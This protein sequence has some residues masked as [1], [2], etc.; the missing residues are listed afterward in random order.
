MQTNKSP[1]EQKLWNN[2]HDNKDNDAANELIEN[3]MY[4][5]RFHVDRMSSHL[6]SNVSRDDLNSFGLI[7]LFDALKKFDPTR[8]LKFDTYASFRVR[9]AIIDGLRKEDWLPRS[10]REKT[11]KIEKVS[12][13]LE[14]DYQRAPSSEEIAVKAGLNAG[15]VE[16]LIQ[17]TLVANVLSIE[18]K[19]KGT[20]IDR[21]EGVGYAIPDKAAILPDEQMM[22]LEMNQEL[23]EGIKSLNENEQM[24]IDLFYHKELTLTEIGQV[25]GLTTSRISQ[26][27]RKA[28]FK[29]RHTLQKIQA[30]ST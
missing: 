23:A 15:E 24:V 17:D 22:K 10:T 29:L 8:D 19:R 21:H 13:E 11:K 2:W 3:Y 1:L 28:I 25:L 20:A 4:L 16:T 9:G 18:E 26:I 12:L 6:P 5:V 14:Q 30:L 27:H 7:G